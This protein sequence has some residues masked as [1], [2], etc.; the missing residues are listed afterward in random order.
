MS[1]LAYYFNCSDVDV[2]ALKQAVEAL[3]EQN[4]IVQTNP[5]DLRMAHRTYL[6]SNYVMEC[7]TENRKPDVVDAQCSQHVFDRY[8]LCNLVSQL[9]EDSDISCEELFQT[10]SAVESEYGK[11][12][13]IKQ[14]REKIPEVRHRVLFYDVCHDYLEGLRNK[15]N[16]RNRIL[17]ASDIHETINDISS[18]RTSCRASCNGWRTP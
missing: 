10:T 2:Y 16:F 14:C 15:H 5:C 4:L 7:V 9:V 18:S 12:T 8:D 1:D 3:K 17:F 11:M 13:F 6:V